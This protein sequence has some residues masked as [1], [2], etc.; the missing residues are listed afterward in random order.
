MTHEPILEFDVQDSVSVGSV[1]GATMLDSANVDCFG[2]E[3]LEHVKRHAG[4]HLLLDFGAVTYLSSAALTELLRVREAAEKAGGSVR[5]CSVSRDIFRIFRIT[6]MDK[7][8]H[9]VDGE[10]CETARARLR[11]ALAVAADEAAW[12][13]QNAEG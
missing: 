9:V 1:T 8:F 5:L 13:G 6:N 11:R 10:D 12:A 4:T 7:L 3:A 2:N